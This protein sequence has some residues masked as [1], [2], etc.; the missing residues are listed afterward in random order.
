MQKNK[1]I[2]KKLFAREKPVIRSSKKVS[3]PWVMQYSWMSKAFFDKYSWMGKYTPDW[4]NHYDKY[5]DSD[6]A[7]QML[8]KEMR[9]WWRDKYQGRAL[10]LYNRETG[11]TLPLTLGDKS[12][13]IE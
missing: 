8:N 7:L 2:I 6:H 4:Q 5:I 10:R 1:K 11:E 12:I 13:K 3:K 9:S